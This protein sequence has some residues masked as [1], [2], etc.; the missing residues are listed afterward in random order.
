M[1]ERNVLIMEDQTK[2]KSNIFQWAALAFEFSFMLCLFAPIDIFF[3]NKDEYWFTFGQLMSVTA[4]AFVA[5]F[6]VISVCLWGLSKI[7]VFNYIYA[8]CTCVLL[9][10]YVQGN[11]IPRNYGVLNGNKRDWASYTGYGI[12]SIV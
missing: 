12:A 5:I 11:D 1:F 8:A 9:Y 10:L 4:I 3:A 2:K 7:K 6:S